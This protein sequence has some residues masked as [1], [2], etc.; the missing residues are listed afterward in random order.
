[1]ADALE[2]YGRA[3]EAAGFVIEAMREPKPDD[4]EVAGA[5]EE[6]RWRRVPNFLM[7][8]ARAS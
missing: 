3:L 4:R 7:V 8:R 1:V 2:A 6:E 5:P